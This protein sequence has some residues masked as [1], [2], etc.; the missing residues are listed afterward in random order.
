MTDNGSCYR[1][2]AFG[3]ACRKLGLRHVRTKPYTPRTIGKAERFIQTFNFH[4]YDSL[5]CF[6]FYLTRLL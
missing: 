5:V 2:K 1:S 6:L 3:K 4:N